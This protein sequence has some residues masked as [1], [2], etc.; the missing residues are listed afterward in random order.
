M[1]PKV[2]HKISYGL[3]VI[4]STREG[5]FN[6]QIAN[7]VFQISADPATVA[8]SI[9]RNNLTNE[10]I[11]A[12][13]VFSVSILPTTVALDFIGH[14]GFKSGRDIDKYQKVSFKPGVTGAPV[15]LEQ[16]VGYLEAEVIDSIEVETHTLFIGKVI[17]A[18]VLSTEEPMTYA[19]YH[20]V[21]RGSA[22][23]TAPTYI[24]EE[25][26]V[27]NKPEGTKEDPK[28]K[29]YQCT[30]CG[31]VYDPAQGDPDSGIAPGTAFEDIP[32]DWVCPVCGVGKDQFEPAE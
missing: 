23:P 13:K 21:K 7:T 18:E 20:Q 10:F 30:V 1:D 24:K 6:G 3:Y 26:N 19:Y 32:E 29:K 9:N 15:L 4:G 17:D 14:F 12:S 5:A 25:K 16:T 2:F 22:P 28:M 11:K 8:V 27:E 31:Y